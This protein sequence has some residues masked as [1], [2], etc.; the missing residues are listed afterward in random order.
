MGKKITVCAVLFVLSGMGLWVYSKVPDVQETIAFYTEEDFT[1]DNI[2][3]DL[4]GIADRLKEEIQK[5]SNDFTIYM[6][7]VDVAE[8]E[9]INS[10]LDGIFGSGST[11]QQIGSVGES[12]KK[13]K[14]TIEKTM[15]YYAVEAYLNQTPIPDSQERAK[16]LYEVIRQVMDT[17]ITDGMT[18]YEKEL[19]LHD[20]L[21]THCTY[22]ENV[23]QSPDSDIY[24]AYGALVNGD[25]VCNGYAE[26]LK[27]LLDC[28]GVPSEFVTGTA[29]GVEHAWNLVKLGD[30]WYHMDATWDDPLPDGGEQ[31]VH[32]YFNVSDEVIGQSHVWKREEYPEADSMFWNYYVRSQ[33]YFQGFDDYKTHA[34]EAMVTEEADHYEAV[35]EGY[36]EHKEDMQ[37][38]F[39]NNS[40]YSRVNWHCFE[41]GSYRVLVL[42]AE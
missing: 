21:V 26:A 15:N 30:E 16:E 24:R 5:G 2:Y 13:V 31:V 4:D 23:I 27:L 36:V 6:K 38:L 17:Q 40:R 20:Y 37:F 22:S 7:D 18:D 19:T 32:P 9:Q 8:L 11:Y 25:A 29:G 41:E 12:Y 33:T 3:T 34:Y 1:E 14:I 39:E 42:N 28:A 35:V 10:A